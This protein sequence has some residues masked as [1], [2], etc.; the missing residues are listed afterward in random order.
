MANNIVSHVD[1]AYT[2][3]MVN[4][5]HH[6]HLDR[7]LMLIQAYVNLVILLAVNATITLWE[8]VWH[9]VIL[10]YC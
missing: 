8:V 7:I 6:V 5:W 10:F 9:V 4:V 1:K 2:H 3:L